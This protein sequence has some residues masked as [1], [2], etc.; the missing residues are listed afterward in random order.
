MLWKTHCLDLC[1]T[2]LEIYVLSYC[3]QFAVKVDFS[4]G[5]CQKVPN[6]TACTTSSGVL[7]VRKAL[8]L[9]AE[10][11]RCLTRR[12]VERE[13]PRP[14]PVWR[15]I[16]AAFPHESC[17]N[18]P[19]RSWSGPKRSCRQRTSRKQK[20]PPRLVCFGLLFMRFRS[21]K[22]QKKAGNPNWLIYSAIPVLET[23]DTY[24]TTHTNLYSQSMYI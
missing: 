23:S 3:S 21:S 22:H 14:R 17:P 12:I 4:S 16:S 10:V 6:W 20:S 9:L 2:W 1:P 13:A 15:W 19:F 11:W 24:C 8:S 7:F 5:G 18:G